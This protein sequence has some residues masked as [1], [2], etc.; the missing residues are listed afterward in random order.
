M[1]LDSSKPPLSHMTTILKI[2]GG[3]WK[4]PILWYVKDHTRRF[5]ELQHLITG[6][7]KQM[8]TKQLRELEEEGIITRKVYPE[9]PPKVEYSLTRIGQSLIPVLAKLAEWEQWYLTYGKEEDICP[10]PPN[11]D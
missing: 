2:I 7:T 4:L 10:P 9:I 1:N 11:P 6:I 3:K 5:G 8:L